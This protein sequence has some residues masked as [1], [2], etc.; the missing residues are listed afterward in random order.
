MWGQQAEPAVKQPGLWSDNAG[1]RAA[2][3]EAAHRLLRGSV[4]CSRFTALAGPRACCL[5]VK[6]QQ[7][8]SE[9]CCCEDPQPAAVTPVFWEELWPASDTLDS[10]V[11]P[12][13]V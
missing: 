4:A 5:A 13:M 12:P 1:P 10:W 6:W 11:L 8:T 3:R 2:L 7:A 9:H